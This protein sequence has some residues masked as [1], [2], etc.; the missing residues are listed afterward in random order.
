MSLLWEPIREADWKL[1]AKEVA[2]LIATFGCAAALLLTIW[3]VLK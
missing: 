2:V 3:A 1:L